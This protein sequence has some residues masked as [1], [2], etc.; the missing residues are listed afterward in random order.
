[1]DGI[2]VHRSREAMGKKL[3]AKIKS[4]MQDRVN[5]I[6]VVIPIPET[7]NTA[8]AVVSRELGIPLSSAFVKVSSHKLWRRLF[9]NWTPI[10]AMSSVLSC[11][12]TRRRGPRV[13]AGS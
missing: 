11:S 3:A 6:D 9:T 5:E 4:I 1:M 8:A 13:Y 10:T 7:A 12:H 2:S